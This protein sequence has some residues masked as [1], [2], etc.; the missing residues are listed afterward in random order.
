M[1]PNTG[2]LP[3]SSMPMAQGS[4]RHI[5]GGAIVVRVLRVPA[6]S[7][8]KVPLFIPILSGSSL[9][10]PSNPSQRSEPGT[11]PDGG[12]TEL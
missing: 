4:S 8:P 5:V 12:G 6:L 9:P 3:A 2:P 1:E 7:D 11:W 10:V